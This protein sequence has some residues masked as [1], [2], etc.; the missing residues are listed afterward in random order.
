MFCNIKNPDGTPY[1][2]DCRYLLK[3]AIDEAK[4]KCGIEFEI[5]T[6]FEFYLFKLDSEGEPTKIPF[7]NAGYMDIAP[8]DHGENVRRDICFTLEQMGIIPEASHHEAG[9]GQN[10]VD[11]HYASPLEA[12]DNASTFKWI[13][14]T[15][16]VTNGLHASFSPKPLEGK[17]GSG[18]HINISCYQ[19]EKM[20]NVIA[21]ILNRI[22]EITYYLNPTENSYK[23]LCEEKAPHHVCWG[24]Q[25]RSAIIRVPANRETVKNSGN[26]LELISPDPSCNTYIAITLLIHAAIEG[27]QNNMIPPEPV[28]ENLFD[29]KTAKSAKC[30]TLP[31][32]LEEAKALAEKS[33]FVK[34]ILV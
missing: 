25:N 22:Q 23:R 16:A 1:K 34:R 20:P 18:L 21:G 19:K 7:D 12:A 30:K 2:K 24:I 10:E 13:V 4:E 17:P 15:K 9:P 31:A 29:S 6:Q 5:G 33:E 8:L 28:S 26:H 27:I 14:R 3:C 32:S 11:F